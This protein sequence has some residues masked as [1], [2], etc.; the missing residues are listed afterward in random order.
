MVPPAPPVPPATPVER[1]RTAWQRRH[2]TD[3]VFDFWTALGWTLLTCGIYAFYILYQLVR[4]DRDHNAR[5]LELL[6]GATAHA[7]EQAH[8]RGLADELRPAFER[9]STN[10]AVL[11][12]QTTQFRDPVIWLILDIISSG[13]ARIVA[14]C[15]LDGDLVDHDHAEGAIEA[16]L[17]EIYGRLG[18][19][20]SA[21]DP[22]RLKGRHNYAARIIVT[23]VTCGIYGFWWLYDVMGEWNRHF[24]QNWRW[25]DGL[26]GAIQGLA[27]PQDV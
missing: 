1:V 14:Y 12:H 21:P 17:S 15:L 13:I 6:D 23:I 19:P 20:V 26:A 7:W 3:Y 8:A 16:E 11:R 4:R 24:E 22:G 5:R 10:M 18:V 9:I 27:P 25:E 2:E